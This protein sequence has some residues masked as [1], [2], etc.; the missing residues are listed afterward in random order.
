MKTTTRTKARNKPKGF[1]FALFILLALCSC[2][3]SKIF[4][5]NVSFPD[6]IWLTK[7][8]LAFEVV[9]EDTSSVHNVIFNIRNTDLYKYN[10]LWLFI[11]TTFPDGTVFN[12]TIDYALA[13]ETG[14]WLGDG[15]GGFYGL[16]VPYRLKVKFPASGTYRFVIQQAM[17]ENKLIGISDFGLRIEKTSI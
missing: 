4:E 17:R 14:A 10:N 8:K 6:N 7:N 12:D 13:N 15:L 5:Q 16:K 11:N 1:V 3:Q 2:D 9:I